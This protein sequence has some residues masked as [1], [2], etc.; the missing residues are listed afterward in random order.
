MMMLYLRNKVFALINIFKSQS[1]VSDELNIVVM[2][3]STGAI[4]SDPIHHSDAYILNRSQQILV[5]NQI[6]GHKYF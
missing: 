2:S 3:D 6:S 5:G 4:V 1:I